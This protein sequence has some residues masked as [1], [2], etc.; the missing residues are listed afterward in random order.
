MRC[1]FIYVR[2]LVAT[3]DEGW[4]PQCRDWRSGDP[5]GAGCRVCPCGHDLVFPEPHLNEEEGA[6]CPV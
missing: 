1:A 3:E 5:Y 2:E 4:C 6:P